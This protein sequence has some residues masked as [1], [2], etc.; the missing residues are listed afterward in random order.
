MAEKWKCTSPIRLTSMEF[1]IRYGISVRLLDAWKNYQDFPRY[2]AIW[3]GNR[4]LWSVS[5]VDTWLRNR[6]L[7]H[8]GIKPRWLEVVGHPAANQTV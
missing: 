7:G 1:A 4:L 2:A 8:T 3:D 5:E 6:R